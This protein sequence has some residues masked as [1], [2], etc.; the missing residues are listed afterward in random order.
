MDFFNK[1]KT[2]FHV[3]LKIYPYMQLIKELWNIRFFPLILN[4]YFKQRKNL[5]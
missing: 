3:Q 4:V 1:V 5:I 2:L